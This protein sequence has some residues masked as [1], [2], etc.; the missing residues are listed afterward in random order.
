MLLTNWKI[1]FKDTNSCNPEIRTQSR[2]TVKWIFYAKRWLERN[3]VLKNNDINANRR[4]T[5]GWLTVKWVL[6]WGWLDDMMRN[7]RS[8]LNGWFRTTNKK[9]VVMNWASVLIEYSPSLFTTATMP[10]GAEDFTS[11]LSIYKQ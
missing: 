3:W 9:S 2:Q 5:E 1:I 4:C 8:N 6:I 11:A 10:P 7:S